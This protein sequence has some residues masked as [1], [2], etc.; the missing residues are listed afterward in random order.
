[1][2]SY[3][4][5]RFSREFAVVSFVNE[6]FWAFERAFHY[7]SDEKSEATISITNAVIISR[8]QSQSPQNKKQR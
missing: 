3:E 2:F 5:R 8:G 4:Q 1:M 6:M 7:S